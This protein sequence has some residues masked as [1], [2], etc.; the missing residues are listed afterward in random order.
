MLRLLP[1]VFYDVVVGILIVFRYPI[2]VCVV[3]AYTGITYVC[4][5]EYRYCVTYLG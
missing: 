5:F 2:L 1:Y 4:E 3:L